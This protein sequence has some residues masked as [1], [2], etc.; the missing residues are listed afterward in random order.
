MTFI[1]EKI[2]N[3]KYEHKLELASVLGIT[4]QLY[5][6]KVEIHKGCPENVAFDDY[7]DIDNGMDYQFRKHRNMVASETLYNIIKNDATKMDQ[8]NDFFNN[9]IV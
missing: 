1:V 7:K 8:L 4:E 9:T 2:F 5:S 3:L 6:T